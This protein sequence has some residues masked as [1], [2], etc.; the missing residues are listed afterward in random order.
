MTSLSRSRPFWF[1]TYRPQVG[2]VY[3]AH[4]ERRLVTAVRLAS[5]PGEPSLDDQ[6]FVNLMHREFGVT[7]REDPDPYDPTWPFGATREPFRAADLVDLSAL[8]DFQRTVM[9][10]I[11]QIPSGQMHSYGEVARRVGGTP[12]DV[13]KAIQSN[14]APLVIPCHRVVNAGRP[15]KWKYGGRLK[16]RLLEYEGNDFSGVGSSA[17][18]EDRIMGGESFWM[19]FK[20][21]A[22]RRGNRYAGH[23]IVK[24]LCAFLNAEGGELLIGVNDDGSPRGI[25]DDHRRGQQHSSDAY[26]LSLLGLLSRR[27][28]TTVSGL[29]TFDFPRYQG[30]EI[31]VV[32]VNR[33]PTEPVRCQPL[34]S[35]GN[36]QL[37]KSKW[38]FWVREGNRTV[39]Y[40]D[41]D[42]ESYINRRWPA[43]V[44]PAELVTSL[45]NQQVRGGSFCATAAGTNPT[46]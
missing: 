36:K 12:R 28:T 7:I 31:C 34:P 8:S 24:T 41:G 6:G 45:G 15:G 23:R 1:K 5:P 42:M 20:P 38:V 18:L 32:D 40:R 17:I 19:E 21:Q 30:V 26:Q 29:I 11:A 33:S 4:T 2:N 44:K 3:V 9:D 46:A 16:Q 13:G 43:Y 35:R 37:D 25:E 14:P 27:L 39:E 10:A 22:G